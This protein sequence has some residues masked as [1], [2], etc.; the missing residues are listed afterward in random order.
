MPNIAVF[1][2]IPS[3]KIIS[4]A[5]EKPGLPLRDRIARCNSLVSSFTRCTFWSP[6]A[7]SPP[8]VCDWFS[9]R[10]STV[11]CPPM[12]RKCSLGR[13]DL[14]HFGWLAFVAAPVGG[15]DAIAVGGSGFDLTIAEGR[16]IQRIGENCKLVAV[17]GGA[18]HA[19]CRDVRLG[20]AIPGEFD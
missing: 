15:G 8:V 18:V 9:V 19:V 12:G 4:A 17:C 11:A 14:Q 7:R 10:A 13:L 5:N 6:S 1:A 16:C 2:P 20:I 3:A